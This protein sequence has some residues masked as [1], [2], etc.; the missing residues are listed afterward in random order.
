MNTKWNGYEAEEFEFEGFKAIVVFPEEDKKCGK[1]LLKTEYFGAFPEFELEMLER[2]YCVAHVDNST[3]WCKEADTVRQGAFARYI[4]KQYGLEQKCILV[5]MSCGGMQAVYF[6]A[7]YP[8][9]T[10]AAYLDAP[11]INFLSC[12]AGFGAADDS[13]FD[14]FFLYRHL[15][16]TDLMS[17]RNHPLDKIPQLVENDIPVMLVCGDSDD[18]VPYD[19]NG[20]L[21]YKYYQKHGGKIERIL[22]PGCGHH[23]H[24][25]EDN[26]PIIE[27]AE[28]YC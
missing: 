14:E 12:P 11:V 2:G 6:A 24:G 8:E 3:R 17:Y 16:K 25:L 13:M 1:W 7:K 4:S 9:L 23:P 5:G 19:E 10:A 22:K 18:V 21:L 26:T 27:F 15:S 20:K 28:K